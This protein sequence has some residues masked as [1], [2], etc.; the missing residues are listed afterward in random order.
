M[1]SHTTEEVV[2]RFHEKQVQIHK[3]LQKSCPGSAIVIFNM[4]NKSALQRT[5]ED[6]QAFESGTAALQ[7]K[8]DKEF[9][10][11]VKQQTLIEPAGCVRFYA[12]AFPGAMYVKRFT[13]QVEEEYVSDRKYDINVYWSDGREIK[14]EIFG[15][16]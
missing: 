6:R 15:G 7:E 12:L 2:S 8:F 10:H 5:E 13:M 14:K 11:I 3:E 1:S 4:M 16:H 9:I